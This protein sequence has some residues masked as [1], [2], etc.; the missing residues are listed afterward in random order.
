MTL[1]I[2]FVN[3]IINEIN[4]KSEDIERLGSLTQMDI[5]LYEK[6]TNHDQAIMP[7]LMKLILL[8]R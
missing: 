6:L 1:L 7:K 8:W 4:E 2:T 3:K 5:L